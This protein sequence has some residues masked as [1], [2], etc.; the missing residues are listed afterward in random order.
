[1]WLMS[2]EE[3]LCEASEVYPLVLFAEVTKG[4]LQSSAHWSL[5]WQPAWSAIRIAGN[6]WDCEEG[7]GRP[8][9]EEVER[10]VDLLHLVQHFSDFLVLGSLCILENSWELLRVYVYLGQTCTY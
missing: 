1:M 6:C 5:T 10:V 8:L 2:D 4:E 9:F 3:S 7:E